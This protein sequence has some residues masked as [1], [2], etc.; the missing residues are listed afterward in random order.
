MEKHQFLQLSIQQFEENIKEYSIAI[1]HVKKEQD[2][3][4]F[5]NN[6]M[7]F[8]LKKNSTQMKQKSLHHVW[9]F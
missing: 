7:R 5:T 8:A 4:S 2:S 6:A 1:Y 9:V 3:L